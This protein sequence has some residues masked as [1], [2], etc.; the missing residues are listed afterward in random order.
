M[1]TLKKKKLA[2]VLVLGI[3]RTTTTDLGRLGSVEILKL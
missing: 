2:I 3:L 1:S